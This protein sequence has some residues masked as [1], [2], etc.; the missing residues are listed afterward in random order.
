MSQ[1]TMDDLTQITARRV[2]KIEVELLSRTGAL[3]GTLDG[4]SGGSIEYVNN[5][6]VKG[7]G[8]L[9]VVDRNQDIDWLN[10]RLRPCMYINQYKWS[11]G[12]FLPS[13]P[14]ENWTSEGRRWTVELLDKTSILDQDAATTS[15]SLPA[16]TNVI[17]TVRDLILSSG[18]QVT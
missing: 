5:R 15:Y 17:N 4:V 18:E 10:V 13:T 3:I 8:T 16:G 12:V 6:T 7:G 11:L 1:P 2:T 9:D 14:K